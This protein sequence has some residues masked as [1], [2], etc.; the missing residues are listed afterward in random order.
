MSKVLNLL[1]PDYNYYPPQTKRLYPVICLV[2]VGGTGSNVAQQLAQ[3]L[4]MFGKKSYFCL[5]DFDTIEKKNINNQ[6]FVESNIGKKKAE[7]LAGRYSQAYGIPVHSFTE[8]YVEDVNTLRKL[9]S[10][11]YDTYSGSV[12]VVLP[13]LIGCVD[14]NYTRRV[15]HELFETVPNLLYLDSGNE[16]TTVPSDY[17]N[18][19]KHQWTADELKD[20]NFS[21]WTGQVCAGLKWNGKTILEP[22]ASRFPEIMLDDDEIKPSQLS[23]EELSASDPQRLQTNKMA[24]LALCSY[25]SELFECGTISKSLTVFHAQK[26]YMKSEPI[27]ENT[28]SIV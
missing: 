4:M 25:L 3:M 11:D 19:P 17:P 2:G 22:V 23:C 13:I 28:P 20:Y 5:A 9:F 21:G 15:F 27:N 10:I 24:A 8:S 26:G 12:D 6:L 18:R 7:I 14:N 16:S 1:S